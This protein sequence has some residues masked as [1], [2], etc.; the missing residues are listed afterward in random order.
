MQNLVSFHPWS[1]QSYLFLFNLLACCD[2]TIRTIDLL[3]SIFRPSSTKLVS[4]IFVSQISKMVKMSKI[5][6][7]EQKSDNT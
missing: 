1:G 2:A 5:L 6:L 7:P 4:Q 3:E